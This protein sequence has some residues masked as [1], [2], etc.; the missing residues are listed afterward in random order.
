MIWKQL[1]N[2]KC[3]LHADTK[4]KRVSTSLP[5]WINGDYIKLTKDRDYLLCKGTV[6]LGT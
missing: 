5:E 3:N 4:Q 2:E 1:F 6:P